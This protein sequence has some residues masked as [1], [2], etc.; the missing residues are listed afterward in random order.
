MVSLGRGHTVARLACRYPIIHVV[1]KAWFGIG[2]VVEVRRWDVR[3]VL[4]WD[5]ALEAIE[6]V[7]S[8]AGSKVEPTYR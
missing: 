2:E 7:I 4:S 1:E 5:G 3:H 6:R 8:K